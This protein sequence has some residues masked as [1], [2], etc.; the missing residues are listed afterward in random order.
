MGK[1]GNFFTTGRRKNSKNTTEASLRPSILA[2]RPGSLPKSTAPLA[3]IDDFKEISK[4]EECLLQK[5][6]SR[7]QPVTQN[8]VE[9]T[10]EYIYTKDLT[11]LYNDIVSEWNSKG[12]SSDS[13]WSPDWHSSSETIKN[14]LYDS[15]L[16]LQT[17]EP[18]KYLVT[19][20]AKSTTPN[21]FRSLT[22]VSNEDQEHSTLNH[23]QLLNRNPFAELEGAATKDPPPVLAPKPS[24]RPHSSRVLTLDIFLR[25][26]EQSISNEFSTTL[27]DDPYSSADEM[28][29]KSAVRRSGKRRKSQ[30]SGDAPN[31]DRNAA[32]TSAKEDAVFESLSSESVAEQINSSERKVKTP[33]Q[34]TAAAN[35]EMKTGSS[36][37]ACTK[38][39]M[40]KNKQ[41]LP[42]SSPYR[43]KSLKKNQTDAVPLSPGGLK[44]QGK[45]S[46]AKR[47]M[48]RAANGG[49]MTKSSSVEKLSFGES[50][51]ESLKAASMGGLSNSTSS[52]T[53]GR[54]DSGHHSCDE[55]VP[56]RADKNKNGGIG[57]T[58][59][60]PISSDLDNP[61]PRGAWDASRTVTTK[62]NL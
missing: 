5:I 42:A 23:K 61:K 6:Y 2:A 49:A 16:T 32:E 10:E 57:T 22:N 50:P 37:K 29:K 8:S 62:V 12:A 25:R 4:S 20:A 15:N 17:P 52:L 58:N 46:S 53:E 34:M 45:D 21:F 33:Q 51:A 39:E 56:L 31:G 60:K 28:D 3:S 40:E 14:T 11:P 35:H 9:G 55:S 36:H 38:M 48:E 47:Q 19:D 7:N 43:R 44:S 27:L 54:P 18:E 41:Q 30:S 1:F 24:E 26:T 13:E 59:G